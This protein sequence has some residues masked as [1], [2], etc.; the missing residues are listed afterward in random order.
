MDSALVVGGTRFIGRHLVEE[1]LAHNYAVTTF[2]RGNH[3]DPFAE[4]DRVHHVQ[5]D[6][7]DRK[8]LLTA[9]R[10]VQPDAVFD[11][12]AYEPR[13][14][15]AATDIF[16]GVDA[17]VFV[18]SGAAYAGE[19]VPKRED[20]TT[21]ESCTAEEATDDSSATYG[22]RKAAADR[23]VFQAA[24]RGVNAM[25][26][27]PP[28]V[29]GPHDYTERLAYWVDRVAE[30]DEIV[31]P[32]DGTNLWQRVYVEDVAQG[33]RLVAEKGTAGEAYNV[34]DRNAVT[35]DR[36]LDLVATALDTSVNRVYT[37]P[38]E[39]SIADLEP[40]DFPLYRDYPHLLDTTKV[41]ALGYESTP[42]GEAM[43]R[44]VDAH[45]E[46]GRTGEANGPSRESEESLLDV[47]ETV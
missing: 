33:M 40:T 26:V 23:I 29:Y 28:V 22:A 1:L 36:M 13:A 7:T 47:L 8:A 10:E 39:L 4:D 21:L 2:N 11:C 37:S 15:E 35:L 34:G 16:G 25:S 42:V 24:E 9:K 46:H 38:R 5:G 3:D 32:G 6:R 41:A 14:V 18:S 19:D 44:T 27:R 43:Q 31:V 12:V 20:E 17:Y 30:H 45:R